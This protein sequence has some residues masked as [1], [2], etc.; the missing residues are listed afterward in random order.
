MAQTF[1]SVANGEKFSVIVN[2]FKSKGSCPSGG[3]DDDPGDGQGCW[4]DRRQQ[5]QDRQQSAK[6]IHRQCPCTHALNRALMIIA[7]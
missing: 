7:P 4:N 3:V 6:K 1:A 2:H 5:Q